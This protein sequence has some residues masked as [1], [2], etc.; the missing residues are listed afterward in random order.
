MQRK[1][2]NGELSFPAN[3]GV[4]QQHRTHGLEFVF[5]EDR[6]WYPVPAHAESSDSVNHPHHYLNRNASIILAE[7]ETWTAD[8][9]TV[10]RTVECVE[11]MRCIGDIRLATAFAYLWR[12]SFGGK[13]NDCEDIEKTI[14][15]LRDYLKVKL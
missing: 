10:M 13:E 15:W 3:P 14:W 7:N 1:W 2:W 8:D 12:V 4:G 5:E 11:L 9:G 6:N